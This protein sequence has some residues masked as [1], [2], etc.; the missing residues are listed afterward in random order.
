MTSKNEILNKLKE[1]KPKY[2]KDGLIL[3]GLF[4]S[5]AIDKQTKYSDID[6]A[7]KLDYEKFDLKYTGGFSKLLRIDSI[8]GE[9][10]NIFK[11]KIDLVPDSNKSIL[12]DII[13][14]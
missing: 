5:Y 2:E 8:K 6:I 13:Y 14:V 4:G 7:Y 11:T 10:Q 3:L 1:F 9:L 12:K